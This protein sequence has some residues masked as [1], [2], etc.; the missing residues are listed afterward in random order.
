MEVKKAVFAMNP[1]KT[2]RPDGMSA[3]FYHQHWEAIKTGVFSFVR[4][5][6]ENNY[7]D[8]KLNQTHICLIP[9]IENPTTVKD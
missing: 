1:D 2:P 3:A 7:L 5:F 6:F 8:T 4:N 9:K